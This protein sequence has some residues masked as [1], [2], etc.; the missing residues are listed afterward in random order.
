MIQDPYQVLGVSPSASEKEI[1]RAY[2]KLAKKYHPDLNPGD[3]NAAKKMSEINEAYELIKNGGAGRASAAGSSYT[4]GGAGFE[5]V[6]HYIQRGA[7]R[8]ALHVLSQMSD[9]NAM[10]YCYSAI[11]NHGLGNRILALEHAQ[12]AVN[13]EPNNP[14]YQAVLN[15][16]ESGGRIYAEQSAGYGGLGELSKYCWYCCCLNSFCNC[17]R[18][19]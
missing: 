1:T 15:Q 10:W 11:A 12:I 3:E 19:F 17:F 2:R 14:Q 6:A 5:V 9:R 18:C 4:Q 7:Y 16:I 8:E 13:M